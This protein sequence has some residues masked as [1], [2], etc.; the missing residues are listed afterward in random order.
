MVDVLDVV[1]AMLVGSAGTWLVVTWDE[2]R[3]SADRLDRAWP[4][5]TKLA[6]ALGFGPL[7]L[8][9]HFWRTRRTVLGTLLGV[10]AMGLV[11][12]LHAGASTLLH[13][14]ADR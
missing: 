6:A 2:R 8:P 10:L 13:L 9:V 7:A 14:A 5:S 4:T 12:A 1:I 11:F 3:L